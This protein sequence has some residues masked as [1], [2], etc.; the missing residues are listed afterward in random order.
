MRWAALSAGV[1]MVAAVRHCFGVQVAA[2]PHVASPAKSDAESAEGRAR[3]YSPPDWWVVGP[4]EV[5]V[6]GRPRR[7]DRLTEADLRF[8]AGLGGS[9][10]VVF[11][12]V[13][14]DEK[15][16]AALGASRNV[17][18]LQIHRCNLS[19]EGV[20]HLS[21]SASITNLLLDGVYVSDDSLAAV[22]RMEQ[23]EKVTL[24]HCPLVSHDAW[25]TFK[26]AHRDVTFGPYDP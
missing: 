8:I 19:D 6:A 7:G 2:S 18:L 5:L 24:T 21:R 10:K 11:K 12:D 16:L 25:R 15:G 4:G 26:K 13:H 23:L 1:L 20:A 14:I 22:G 9:V 3:A 17:W